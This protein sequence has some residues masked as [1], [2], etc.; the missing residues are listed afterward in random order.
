MKYKI[1]HLRIEPP[2][3][4]VVYLNIAA[5]YFQS[6]AVVHAESHLIEIGVA[7]ILCYRAPCVAESIDAVGGI[8]THAHIGAYLLYA[9]VYIGREAI[10]IAVADM[11]IEKVLVIFR[12]EVFFKYRADERLDAHLD[13]RLV[14]ARMACFSPLVADY[15]VMVVGLLHVEQVDGVYTS[16]AENEH[17]HV[18][19]QFGKR[20][21]HLCLRQ[22]A[23][24][25]L[26]ARLR[27]YGA[28]YAVVRLRYLHF[29]PGVELDAHDAAL[30]VVKLQQRGLE[31]LP[32][33][34]RVHFFGA[35]C[36]SE[37]FNPSLQDRGT[38]V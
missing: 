7:V 18:A 21:Q 6:V 25:E 30:I 26:A 1:Y 29:Q 33:A 9:I 4:G 23:V 16:E 14:A 24:E 35:V 15:S 36:H 20:G 22:G 13:I 8:L 12:R 10:R 3:R 2:R 17:R 37:A 38:E 11:E 27:A 28:L 34:Y 31:Y 5:C 32:D 19:A